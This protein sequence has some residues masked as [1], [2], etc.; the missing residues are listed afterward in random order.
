MSLSRKLNK[1]NGSGG[2]ARSRARSVE[3]TGRIRFLAALV[4]P[5]LL[6]GALTS[7]AANA[8]AP[9]ASASGAVDLNTLTNA[10]LDYARCARTHGLPNLPDPVVDNF[11]N[12]TYPGMTKVSWPQSVLTGCA[13]VWSHVHALRDRFD[14][15]HGLAGRSNQSHF[16]YA[17][18]LDLAKCIRRHGFPSFPDP[19]QDGSTPSLPPGFQKP[20]LSAAAIAALR[21]CQITTHHG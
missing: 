21:T 12:D 16:T 19:N 18:L 7:C 10:F 8:A 13:S 20:N 15:S 5:F 17:Q 11:G 3:P 4:A 2:S 9:A 1:L 6:A 14:A